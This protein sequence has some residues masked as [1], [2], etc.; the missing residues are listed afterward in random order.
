MKFFDRILGND[1]SLKEAPTNLGSDEMAVERYKYLLRNASSKTIEE[2][3]IDAFG[4]L[5]P[6]QLDLL[7]EEFTKTGPDADERP[8]DASAESLA[9]SATRVE[10]SKPGLLTRTF[11]NADARTLDLIGLSLL[12]TIAGYAVASVIISPFFWAEY[13]IDSDAE[14]AASIPPELAANQVDEFDAYDFDF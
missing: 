2:V 13:G 9:R 14:S 10:R 8:S 7:F 11:G 4:R 5:T 3:H 1:L 12:D 6:A